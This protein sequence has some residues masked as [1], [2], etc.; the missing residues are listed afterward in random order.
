MFGLGGVGWGGV[1]AEVETE[2]LLS[3]R[4]TEYCHISTIANDFLNDS[5]CFFGESQSHKLLRLLFELRKMD[6]RKMAMKTRND[7]YLRCLDYNGRYP[8]ECQCSYDVF[9]D[10]A[11]DV[12]SFAIEREIEF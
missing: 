5:D 9:C 3:V 8:K 2:V 1:G 11:M 12:S 10:Y 6:M 7:L 4:P